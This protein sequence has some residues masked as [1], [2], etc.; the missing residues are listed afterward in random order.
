MAEVKF[1]KK[2]LWTAYYR[3]RMFPMCTINYERFQSLQYCMSLV[4]AM[5][6]LYPDN[7]EERIAMA[8]R[9]MEFYNTTPT[10]I[11]VNMGITM[12]QEEKI[13]NMEPSEDRD[14]LIASVNAVKT[15]LMGP[16]AGVG[17]SLGATISAI[18]GSISAGFALNGS[19][20]GAFLYFIGIN[21]Y[22]LGLAWYMYNYSYTNG[23]KFIT[24]MNKSG[25]LQRFMDA[26]TILGLTSLGA[27][28]PSWIGF[29]LNKEFIF[30][31]YAINFQT[32]LN[33]VFPGLVPLTL[34]L[35][36]ASLYKRKV[37]AIKL[38]IVIFILAFIMSMLGFGRPS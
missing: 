21:I 13:A 12:A 7:K 24:D 36:L 8:K 32:Q 30:N 37:S 11:L 22:E 6:K 25:L 19:I 35:I 3:I 1:D 34:T 10:F 26:A 33:N 18:L 31:G 29:N 28:V 14:V 9:H 27:L 20:F 16:L 23:T 17:D 4:P 38:V 15:S 5:K 2:D